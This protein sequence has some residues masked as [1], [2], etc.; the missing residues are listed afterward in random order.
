MI[1]VSDTS[2]IINLATIGKID[3]LRQ[4]FSRIIIPQAVFNE[5]VVTGQG[6]PGSTEVQYADWIEVR[7]FSN[8]VIFDSIFA[9]D[10]DDGEIEAITLAI[11]LK[12]DRL[13]MDEMKGRELATRL[14]L[15]PIGILG[16]L[17]EAKNRRLVGSIQ[18]LLDQLI[19]DAGFY[20]GKALYL[21]VLSL[22]GE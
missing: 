22:A 14:N 15:K 12:A 3:L 9:E 11:E 17:L 18:P 8:Q 16:I 10:L 13:L 4:L 1:I 19:N 6:L 5:I 2:V 7:H 21:R 20:I